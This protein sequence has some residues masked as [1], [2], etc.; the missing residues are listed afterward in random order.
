MNL[1]RYLELVGH[2]DCSEE[3]ILSSVLIIL[4]AYD[5]EWQAYLEM[6]NEV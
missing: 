6:A 4:D 1:E 2:L 5:Q 3:T